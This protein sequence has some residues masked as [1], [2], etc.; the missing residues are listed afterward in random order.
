MV[1]IDA[2]YGLSDSQLELKR[3]QQEREEAELT[4]QRNVGY[5]AKLVPT[6]IK[7]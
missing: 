1:S 6:A 5:A 4:A 2:M 3:I 7:T